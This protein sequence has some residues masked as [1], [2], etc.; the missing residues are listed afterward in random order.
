[1]KPFENILTTIFHR[2]LIPNL[3]IANVYCYLNEFAILSLLSC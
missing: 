3:S 2:L 1:M